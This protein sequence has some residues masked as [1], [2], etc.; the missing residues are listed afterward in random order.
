[1]SCL[2]GSTDA[3]VVITADATL[4]ARLRGYFAGFSQTFPQ[5]VFCESQAAALAFL[6]RHDPCC[7]IMEHQFGSAEVFE[8]L[9]LKSANDWLPMI[10]LADRANFDAACR[11][12]DEGAQDCL[13]TEDLLAGRI[14]TSVC[15]ALR[16]SSLQKQVNHLAHNDALTGLINRSLLMNRLEQALRRCDRYSE[17]CALL[18]LNLNHFKPVNETYGHAVGDALLRAVA[19][20]VRQNCRST[21]SAARLGGDEFVVLLEQVDDFTGRKVASKILDSLAKPF[22]IDD[23]SIAIS[24]SIG[25]ATYPDT[26]KNAGE[27]LKQADQALDRAKDNS[28][29]HFI[30]FSEQHKHQ[31]SRRHQLETELPKAI[32]R[33]EL[34][35]AY[36]P[37]VGA[38][39]F[40][41]KRLEVLS[42]WPRDDYAVNAMELM[43]MIER[44]NLTDAFHEWLFHTAFGQMKSWQ[45]ENACP[46]L[47]LNIP[48]NYC[49]ST[50]ISNT[51]ERA[52]AAHG[53]RPEK[54]ELEITES[55][56]MRFPERSVQV[57]QALH[58]RGLRIAIDD[59]GTGYSS[60]SYLTH[61]PLDTLKID[62]NFFL[63]QS[64]KDRNRKI[65]EA[66]TALG[67]SLDLEIIAEGVET[68]VQ[69]ALAK[70]VGCDLLQ[71]YYFGRPAFAGGNW[72]EYL[73]RFEHIGQP[74]LS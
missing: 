73:T 43:E 3:I 19:A 14:Y 42:R 39:D 13:L 27:L 21:D 46:D 40:A 31:W 24:A 33:G 4:T 71:G 54:I 8:R 44:L 30:S 11:L 53:I 67:H 2:T 47:C 63:T 60:M 58:D 52:L 20:R 7:I 35:L 15:Q 68:S 28:Q 49:Y 26:A 70:E 25:L 62:R 6:R 48:A 17:R 66:M 74:G 57:L 51:V 22:E 12:L 5:V 50:A 56:L 32:E 37:I 9:R 45:D 72:S 65:I 23:H 34:A 1:M 36:Q 61:L 55:T 41:I 16:A 38:N 29:Q 64:H 69:L 10:V 18:Y 59:F